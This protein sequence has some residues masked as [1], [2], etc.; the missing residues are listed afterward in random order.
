MRWWF[1]GGGDDAKSLEKEITVL[2]DKISEHETRLSRL[3]ADDRQIRGALTLYGLLIWILYVGIWTLLFAR[4]KD[5]LGV[6]FKR[7]LPVLLGP[8]V[9]FSLRWLQSSY[10]RSRIESHSTSLT[11]L[12]KQQ[13]EKIETFKQKT[14]FYSTKSLIERYEGGESSSPSTPSRTPAKAPASTKSTPRGTP[15]NLALQQ[16]NMGKVNT[17]LKQSLSRA[18]SMRSLEGTIPTPPHLS[19]AKQRPAQVQ[20]Q[21][22][23]A[24]TTVTSAPDQ[25][26]LPYER[27][28]Y[29]RVLDVLVGEDE[30][31]PSSRFQ[32]EKKIR[33]RD[34]KIHQLELEIIKLGGARLSESDSQSPS[35]TV[36]QHASQVK[37]EER[38]ELDDEAREDNNAESSGSNEPKSTTDVV[39][40]ATTPETVIKPKEK[41]KS[42][43]SRARPK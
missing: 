38:E 33:E 27:H 16:P 24:P 37:N 15:Q 26:T 5:D 22:A 32:L 39:K 17:P 30:S 3:Q 13:K 9:I 11:A 23:I 18:A 8:V 7:G 10:Y 6:Y 25:P 1:G 28:W 19:G 34:E 20:P 14:D 31:Q 42:V 35:P 2:A 29:D 12:K 41:T 43:R 36:D 40:S 21:T 4:D